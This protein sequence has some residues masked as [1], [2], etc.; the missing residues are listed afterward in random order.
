MI[1][2]SCPVSGR[3]FRACESDTLV[4]RLSLLRSSDDAIMRAKDGAAR[5]DLVQAGPATSGTWPDACTTMA[6]ARR[7]PVVSAWRKLTTAHRGNTPDAPVS[8]EASV[9]P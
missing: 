3:M 9:R 4:E 7:A 5:H 2:G 6:F 1:S 8:A